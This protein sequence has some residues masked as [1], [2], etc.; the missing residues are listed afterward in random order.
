MCEHETI[1]ARLIAVIEDRNVHRPE[2]SYT[3]GLLEGGV[4]AIGAKIREEAAEVIEAAGNDDPSDSHLIHEAADLIYHLFVMLA[5]RGV[6]LAEVEAELA[7]RFGTS[8][9]E[10]KASRESP[11]TTSQPPADRC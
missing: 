7:C 3:T 2:N 6:K 8:G 11:D 5:Y 10:E 9:L 4:A 1:F